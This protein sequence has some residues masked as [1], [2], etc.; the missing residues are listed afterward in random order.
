MSIT[1][2]LPRLPIGLTPTPLHALER[3]SA[4]LGVPR[5]LVKREDLSGLGAGGNKAR[6]LSFLLAEARAQSATVVLTCGGPQSNHC[7]QTAC[8]AGM[9]GVRAELFF[10]DDDPGFCTGNLRVDALLEA[11]LVFTGTRDEGAMRERMHARA[12]ELRRAGET[13]YI[14]GL[15]GSDPLGAAGYA[16]GVEEVARQTQPGAR[17]THMVVAAGSL[18]TL[19]GI[20]LGTWAL[21]MECVVDGISVLWPAER[22]RPALDHLLE[23]TRARYFPAVAPRANYS[24]IDA[25]LGAGYGRPTAAGAEAAALVARLEGL[26][27]DGTYT[28]KAMAGLIAG[29]RDGRYGSDD[30]VLFWH[31]GGIGGFFA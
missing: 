24:I 7:A 2:H 26:V 5:L 13:P 18:G 9:V 28:A 10:W 29:C 21:E 11:R 19:A 15:G 12:E 17:P 4:H 31:T 14:I 23:E 1:A 16:S 20:I 25:Q 6:K 3:L 8:A 30:T 22:A 27:L